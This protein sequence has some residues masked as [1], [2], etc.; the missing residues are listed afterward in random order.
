[1]AEINEKELGTVTGG[2]R[3]EPELILKHNLFGDCPN[4][5]K[6]VSNRTCIGCPHVINTNG[7]GTCSKGAMGIFLFPNEI[8]A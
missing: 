2:A 5:Y 6:E 3:L 7:E 8:Y 1:M 4:G